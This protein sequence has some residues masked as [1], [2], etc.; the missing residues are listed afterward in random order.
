MAI[1]WDKFTV[2]SQEALQQAGELAAQHGN[3]EVQPVHVLV[4][5]VRDAEGIVAPVLAKLGA[6]TVNFE[7]QAMERIN[8][9]PKVSRGTQPPP[10][11]PMPHIPYQPFTTAPHSTHNY[12]STQPLP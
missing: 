3:P 1:R 2:K 8:N 9:L 11:A 4:A 10:R 5:L 6:N 7:C 12:T